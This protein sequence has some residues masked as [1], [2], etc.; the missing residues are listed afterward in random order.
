MKTFFTIA[1]FV[2]MAAIRV[3]AIAQ[4][5]CS[6]ITIRAAVEITANELTLADVLAP[7]SCAAVVRVA[8]RVRLGGAPRGGSVRVIARDEIRDHFQQ[9]AKDES[10]E[11][12]GLRW[13][14]MT[15]P[16]RITVRRKAARAPCAE[17]GRQILAA[18]KAPNSLKSDVS[19]Q[20][21][22]ENLSVGEI[23]CGGTVPRDSGIELLSTSW[24]PSRGNWEARARCRHPQ[25]CVP[26]FVRW[27]GTDNRAPLAASSSPR[28][29]LTQALERGAASDGN[30]SPLVRPGQKAM[31]LWEQDGIRVVVPA[32]SLDRGGAGDSVRARTASGGRVLHAIVVS[33]GLLRVAS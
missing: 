24:D 3:T 15:V 26:F 5:A 22:K 18:A 4:A 2:L 32:V 29:G 28:S 23:E 7:E 16:E 11:A 17:L 8:G 21:D 9:L 12:K 14:E 13:D 33:A 27:P 6:P 19:S 10:L 20:H 1:G 25:D 30:V 31:L